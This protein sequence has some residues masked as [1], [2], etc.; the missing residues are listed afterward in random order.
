MI[1]RIL[2]RI[3][4]HVEEARRRDAHGHASADAHRAEV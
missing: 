3:E 2:Y 4:D 1:E